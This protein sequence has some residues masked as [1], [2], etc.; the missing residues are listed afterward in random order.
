M[1]FHLATILLIAAAIPLYLLG[2]AS[3]GT[4]ALGAAM[5]FEVWFWIR[6]VRGG[7]RAK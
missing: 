1:K 2:F 7:S 5:A 4:L 3:G 6:V